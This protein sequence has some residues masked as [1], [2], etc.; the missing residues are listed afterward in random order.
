M[1]GKGNPDEL[2]SK[3]RAALAALMTAP[4]V[5]A[6]AATCGCGERTLHRWMREPVFKAALQELEGNAIDQAARRLA[7]LSD[8]AISALSWVLTSRDTPVGTRLRAAT[9]ILDQ[10]LRLHELRNLEER[11][12]AL[13]ERIGGKDEQH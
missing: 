13:E 2:S 8:T 11:L 6:A 12:T 10:L 3:Q 5:K 9:S 7:G 4:N 1:A